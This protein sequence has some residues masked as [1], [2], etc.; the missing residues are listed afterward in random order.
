MCF[1][2]LSVYAI[3]IQNGVWLNLFHYMYL[4][5]ITLVQ[6]MMFHYM[7]LLVITLVQF[8]MNWFFEMV[9]RREY[10]NPL[11]TT[12]TKWSNT[13]IGRREFADELFECV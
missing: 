9:D 8:M 3:K 4:L 11:S 10:V 6:F 5:V 13:Q 2:K 12:H 7:Y 1:V